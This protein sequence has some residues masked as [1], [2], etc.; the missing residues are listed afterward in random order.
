MI[1]QATIVKIQQMILKEA[2]LVVGQ[3]VQI[4]GIFSDDNNAILGGL[5]DSSLLDIYGVVEDISSTHLTV[6]FVNDDGN[7]QYEDFP[8][9]LLS[10]AEPEDLFEHLGGM[11][12][13]VNLYAEA[14]VTSCL[15][16]Y[17]WPEDPD[18]YISEENDDEPK[19]KKQPKVKKVKKMSSKTE[20]AFES[21]FKEPED[22]KRYFS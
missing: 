14:D 8:A 19:E 2:P 20:S 10:P 13:V 4:T 11:Q 5:E 18:D 15:R 12:E 17:D 1:S 6:R 3:P 22:T 16:D 21:F 7:Y 9:F